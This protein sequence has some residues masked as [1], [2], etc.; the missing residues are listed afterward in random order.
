MFTSNHP[1]FNFVIDPTDSF[2]H[3]EPERLVD[4]CGFIPY[5]IDVTDERSFQQQVDDNYGFGLSEFNGAKVS[6]DGTYAYPDDP[7][8]K[9]YLKWER[10]GEVAYMYAHAMMSFIKDGKTFV[11]RVD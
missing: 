11:T 8:L 7:P 4:A 1:Q 6:G 9:P 10:P 3:V 5:W 2:I